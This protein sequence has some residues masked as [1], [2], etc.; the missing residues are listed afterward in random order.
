[1]DASLGRTTA[2]SGTA[3]GSPD[4]TA[5]LIQV[6]GRPGCASS[7]GRKGSIPAPTASPARPC[8]SPVQD[9]SG[10]TAR[11][12]SVWNRNDCILAKL[13]RSA[14]PQS[15]QYQ[16]LRSDAPMSRIIRLG[17]DEPV[18]AANIDPTSHRRWR[19]PI[20]AHF[21]LG[22]AGLVHSSSRLAHDASQDWYGE[23]DDRLQNDSHWRSGSK[24]DDT[25]RWKAMG[26]EHLRLFQRLRQAASEPAPLKRIV[27]WGAAGARTPFFSRRWLRSSS[28]STSS[29]EHRGMHAPSGP[30]GSTPFVEVLANIAHPEEASRHPR[31]ATCSC[32][33]TSWNSSRRSHM[34]CASCALPTT[35]SGRADRHLCSSSMLPDH[36]ALGRGG[37]ATAGHSRQYLPY[38]DFWTA[39]AASDS[40]PRS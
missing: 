28:S 2:R 4:I 24:F 3:F 23:R 32:A 8:I 33:S 40:V 20:R 21:V 38:R 36:G 12:R 31:P 30:G 14:Q 13:V 15:R 9:R 39:M 37:A 35:C 6:R 34:D 29:R 18:P 25:E 11:R 19:R 5:L 26:Q 22:Q 10:P 27:D 17:G 1:M 7:S 16:G